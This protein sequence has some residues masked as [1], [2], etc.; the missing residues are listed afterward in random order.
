MSKLKEINN[1]TKLEGFTHKRSMSSPFLLTMED[2]EPFYSWVFFERS[3]FKTCYFSLS[4]I[5]ENQ[6]CVVLELLVPCCNRSTCCQKVL[7]RSSSKILVD[8]SFLCGIIEVELPV[9]DALILKNIESHHIFLCFSTTP[10]SVEVWRNGT[11]FLNTATVVLHHQDHQDVPVAIR[12]H[13]GTFCYDLLVQKGESRAITV[14]DVKFILKSP[15]TENVQARLDM[16]INMVQR[17]KIK[18]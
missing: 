11:K 8:L 15:S 10:S 6:N 4:S 13:T 17:R 7:Y 9:Y 18:L 2:G 12:I 14:K 16:Q 5:N 3:V 1:Q